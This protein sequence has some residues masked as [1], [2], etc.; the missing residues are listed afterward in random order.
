[1]VAHDCAKR[2]AVYPVLA[3]ATG[4]VVISPQASRPHPGVERPFPDIRIGRLRVRGEDRVVIALQEDAEIGN[5]N[6]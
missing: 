4:I 5:P 3:T 6:Y 1:V 2:R